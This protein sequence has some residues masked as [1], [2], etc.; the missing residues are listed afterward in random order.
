MHSFRSTSCDSVF[1]LHLFLILMYSTCS[2]AR[3]PSAW[4]SSSRQNTLSGWC[5][6]YGHFHASV[7]LYLFRL[8]RLPLL[9]S[10]QDKALMCVSIVTFLLM[11]LS[12]W[13]VI[14]RCVYRVI[15][16]LMKTITIEEN[17]IC[18]HESICSGIIIVSRDVLC[19]ISIR[20]LELLHHQLISM[21]MGIFR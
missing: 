21:H 5:V 18:I 1:S 4:S 19:C 7:Q 10:L 8:A 13:F 15:V 9:A 2:H 3:Y 14:R 6:H 11:L 12:V 20:V 16:V 17:V